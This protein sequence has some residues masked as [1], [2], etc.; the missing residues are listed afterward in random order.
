MTQ[1]SFLFSY[2]IQYINIFW[3]TIVTIANYKIEPS[4]YY[5]NKC[6]DRITL[7]YKNN[8]IYIIL[9]DCNSMSLIASSCIPSRI[10][11]YLKH[12][13]RLSGLATLNTNYTFFKS[14]SNQRYVLNC[15]NCIEG[16]IHF[17]IYFIS[18][19]WDICDNFII[20]ISTKKLILSYRQ[21]PV[22]VDIY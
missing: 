9:F 15:Q 12:F 21:I 8:E 5:N 4:N 11:L 13:I 17:N 16:K 19:E 3:T 1:R 18:R 22:T 20:T 7:K 14:F 6:A 2:S 10:Y